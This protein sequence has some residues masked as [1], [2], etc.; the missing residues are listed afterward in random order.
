MTV[1]ECTRGHLF[2]QG[3]FPHLHLAV[4]VRRVIHSP[5]VAAGRFDRERK[6]IHIVF[7]LAML[8]KKVAPSLE[9]EWLLR[10]Q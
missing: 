1:S 5:V 8:S 7:L 2:I 10:G 4:C 6:M 3:K 9:R